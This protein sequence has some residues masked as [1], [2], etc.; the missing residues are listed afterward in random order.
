MKAGDRRI[1]LY[2]KSGREPHAAC[3][4]GYRF[5]TVRKNA[6]G[7]REVACRYCEALARPRLRFDPAAFL[8]GIRKRVLA[9]GPFRRVIAFNRRWSTSF[10]RPAG[11]KPT[12]SMERAA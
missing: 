8:A 3:G 6:D 4:R 11:W 9:P 7:S 10:S 1:T 2:V 5:R 12:P